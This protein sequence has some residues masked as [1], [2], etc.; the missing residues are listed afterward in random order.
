M[1]AYASELEGLTWNCKPLISTLSQIA[2]ETT[3]V[4]EQK[5]ITSVIE[6]KIIQASSDK[7]LPVIYL[8]D[9]IC[10]NEGLTNGLTNSTYIEHFSHNLPSVIAEAH[11]TSGPKVRSALQALIR[12]WGNVFPA[13]TLQE[14]ASRISA[15]AQPN[16][17]AVGAFSATGVAS[18]PAGQQQ[19]RPPSPPL[20]LPP[21]GE[22][23][24]SPGAPVPL[25]CDQLASGEVGGASR[26]RSR[27]GPEWKG[28]QRQSLLAEKD[29]LV[30]RVQAHLQARLPAD[31]QMLSFIASALSIVRQLLSMTTESSDVNAL[32]AQLADLQRLQAQQSRDF[33]QQ[34]PS[35]RPQPVAAACRVAP[36]APVV[37]V[38]QL[39]ASLAAAGVL[40][41]ARPAPSGS[42]AGVAALGNH[43]ISQHAASQHMVNNVFKIYFARKFQCNFC[44]LRFDGTQQEA[45]R[46]HVD[47]HFKDK[48]RRTCKGAVPPSRRWQCTF[49]SV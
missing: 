48:Q 45:F 34:N 27:N 14:V 13:A 12:T 1:D 40:P 24:W 43:P 22:Q 37:D 21:A 9:S 46:L 19:L 36:A 4:I 2:G 44:A 18:C 26:K 3:C 28:E 11:S 7:K 6:Q 17:A 23:Q 31:G 25:H 39:F 49:I 47:W 35:A 8:L 10:K 32:R 33:E 30:E 29:S 15:Q 41:A 38:P 20:P 42:I 5:A 16:S